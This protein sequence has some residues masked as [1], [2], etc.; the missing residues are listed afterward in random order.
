MDLILS[1]INQHGFLAGL[2]VG[3]FVPAIAARLIP[4]LSKAIISWTAAVLPTIAGWTHRVIVLVLAHPLAKAIIVKNKE[5]IMTLED[6]IVN[7]ITAITTA[8]DNA[9]DEEI[10]KAGLPEATPLPEP[11][12]DK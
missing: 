10:A 5:S 7:S 3:T 9:F 1:Q 12:Q 6:A 4:M 11:K 2:F 8:F